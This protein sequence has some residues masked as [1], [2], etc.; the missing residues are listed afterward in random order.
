MD[1][2]QLPGGHSFGY[3]H[4][5]NYSSLFKI[6]DHRY[7]MN[8]YYMSKLSIKQIKHHHSNTAHCSPLMYAYVYEGVKMLSLRGK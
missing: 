4:V 5:D 6:M 8:V 7:L 1:V 2:Q 3:E